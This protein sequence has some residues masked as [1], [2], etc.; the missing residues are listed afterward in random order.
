MTFL[1]IRALT[2]HSFFNPNSCRPS[3]T[4]IFQDFIGFGYVGEFVLLSISVNFRD[5]GTSR[6]LHKIVKTGDKFTERFCCFTNGMISAQRIG[7]ELAIHIAHVQNKI[8]SKN[9]RQVAM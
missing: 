6:I 3:V 8:T 5:S 7:E 2:Y 1:L 9:E 4:S